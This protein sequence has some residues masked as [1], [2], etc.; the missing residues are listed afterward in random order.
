MATQGYSGSVD[1]ISGIRPKNNGTFPLVD[2]HDVYVAAPDVRLDET[3]AGKLDRSEAKAGYTK[4]EV[5][6]IKPGCEYVSC[7]WNASN[8]VWDVRYIEDGVE[9]VAAFLGDDTETYLTDDTITLSRKRI[10]PVDSVNGKTGSVVLSG[11]D[12]HVSGEPE[13]DARTVSQVL[14]SLENASTI[15][16]DAKR[17]KAD[18]AVYDRLA[19]WTSSSGAVARWDHGTF[20][21][22][23]AVGGYLEYING[24]EWVLYDPSL[25]GVTHGI[26]ADEDALSLTFSVPVDGGEP[27]EITFTRPSVYVSSGDMLATKSYADS[28]AA[29][30]RYALVDVQTTYN[31][32]DSWFPITFKQNKTSYTIPLTNKNKLDLSQGVGWY[33][34]YQA[35]DVAWFTEGGVL[36]ST[37]VSSLQFNGVAPVVGETT[38]NSPTT[39]LADRAVNAVT[40]PIGMTSATLA[41]PPFVPGR[42]RDLVVRMTL[43]TDVA[44]T[45]TGPSSAAAWDSSG[46]PS[47]TFAAGTHFLRL[48]EVAQNVFHVGGIA[49][50]DKLNST[51]AA[52]A[53]DSTMTYDIGKHVTY[54]GQLYRCTTAVATAGAWNAANWTA[55]DMTTPDATLDIAAGR[56]RLV[57][58]DGTVLWQ[59]GYD[60]AAESSATLSCDK[61]NLFEFPK[62]AAEFSDA[63]GYEIGDH[64]AYDNKIYKFTAQHVAGPWVGTDAEE[65]P[66]V[67]PAFAL[68]TAPSGKVGGFIL[69]I[70]NSA[71]TVAATASLTGLD[72]AFS[73]VVPKGQS[74]AQMLTFAAGERAELYFTQTAFKVNNLPTWKLVKQ[75]VENG[76]AQS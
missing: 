22:L 17:D 38:L 36:G 26:T 66:V 71:G 64:V 56:L 43:S 58:T 57:D 40:V 20:W 24:Q 41:L 62:T 75:I 5:E 18:M 31:I 25:D 52:P 51:S 2:A 45:F 8:S 10:R 19:N 49:S 46:D 7:T 68:P 3:L 28:I 60:L 32:P 44:V 12:I 74:L 69:D 47:G 29:D 11:T 72:T 9:V 42:V 1:L 63:T 39:T 48:T 23:P 59:Q 27:E 21:E 37:A 73:I 54:N 50:G 76:G 14:Q 34:T 35:E 30:L 13:G 6:S 61:V 53:F 55:E 33:L 65:E 4:W 15:S 67:T 70:D 16:L